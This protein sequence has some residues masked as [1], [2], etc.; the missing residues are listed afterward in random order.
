MSFAT[1]LFVWKNLGP[2]VLLLLRWTKRH[3]DAKQSAMW[4][5]GFDFES[6]STLYIDTFS[7]ACSLV[8]QVYMLTMISLLRGWMSTM[9]IR[10]K[11]AEGEVSPIWVD[12]VVCY[13]NFTRFDSRCHLS[14]LSPFIAQR[15]NLRSAW[16]NKLMI[17]MLKVRAK[18]LLLTTPVSQG[19]EI[20]VQWITEYPVGINMQNVTMMFLDENKGQTSKNASSP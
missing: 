11:H 12:G 13:L 3:R 18:R 5:T 4:L 20:A 16:S 15:N 7:D 19:K 1:W 17:R 6:L 2:L 10:G 9:T 8:F 14:L